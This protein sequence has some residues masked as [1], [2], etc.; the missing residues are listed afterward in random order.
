MPGRV[1]ST[2]PLP[3]CHFLRREPQRARGHV[4]LQVLRVPG[5]R[6]GQHVRSL[7]ERPRQPDLRGRRAV[8]SGDGQDVVAVSITRVLLASLAGDGEER[9]V[10]HALLTAGP[11]ELSFRGGRADAVGVLHADHRRDG[12]GLGQVLGP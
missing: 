2:V 7:L 11:Q 12:Q 10:R 8:R 6:D 4:G 3:Q 9:H 1:I 5:S